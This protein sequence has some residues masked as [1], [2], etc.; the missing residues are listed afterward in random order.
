MTVVAELK[1]THRATWAAGDYAA[2]HQLRIDKI[3]GAAEADHADFFR[4]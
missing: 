2:E 1:Q 4:R 3:F